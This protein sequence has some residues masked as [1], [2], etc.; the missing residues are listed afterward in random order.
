MTQGEGRKEQTEGGMVHLGT[1]NV[2]VIIEKIIINKNK[3]Y[4]PATQTKMTPLHPLQ[5][6]K[7]HE[8]ILSPF[9]IS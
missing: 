5:V 8:T 7:M 4:A 1:R 2:T 3:V 9:F 6:V